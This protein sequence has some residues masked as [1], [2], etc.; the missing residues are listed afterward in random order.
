MFED[1]DLKIADPVQPM[2]A[3][4]PDK[5]LSCFTCNGCHLTHNCT[6]TCKTCMCTQTCLCT[7][8]CTGNGC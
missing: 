6:H 2:W 4:H 8:A 3:W 5:T 1:V 7:M